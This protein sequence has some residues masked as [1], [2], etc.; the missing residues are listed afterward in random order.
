M[1]PGSWWETKC[2]RCAMVY[3]YGRPDNAP[4]VVY[5]YRCPHWRGDRLC[6]RKLQ[7][8]YPGEGT[9]WEIKCF[10][11]R[12]V[13]H[14]GPAGAGPVATVETIAADQPYRFQ[15]GAHVHAVKLAPVGLP[16][17]FVSVQSVAP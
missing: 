3:H 10:R 13:S 15:S 2:N 1:G 7:V 11:C 6:N 8:G 16:D 17:L 5:E 9:W 14:Y 4:Y 12:Q